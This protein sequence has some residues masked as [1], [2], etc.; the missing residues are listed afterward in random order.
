M[1]LIRIARTLV[2]DEDG[3]TAVEYAVM[4]AGIL[5]AIIAG[6]TVTGGGARQW[7]NNVDSKIEAATS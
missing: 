5:V 7:W 2:T 6:I 3:T 4:L 1:K